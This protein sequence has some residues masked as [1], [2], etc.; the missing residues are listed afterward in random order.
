MPGF[1][2]KVTEPSGDLM[3]PMTV[4]CKDA[5]TAEKLVRQLPFVDRNDKVEARELRDDVMKSAFG[6]Q[7]EDTIAIRVDWVWRGDNPERK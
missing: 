7:A 2:V 4:Y 1:V 6:V 5:E 3:S